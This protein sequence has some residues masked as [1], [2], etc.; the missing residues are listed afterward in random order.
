M[1]NYSY[2]KM[3]RGPVE[4]GSRK[5]ESEREIMKISR[6]DVVVVPPT[7]SIKSAAETMVEYSTRRLPIVHAGT[8]TIQGIVTTRDIIDFL[9]G[10][11]KYNII[12]EKHGGNF[13]A[14]INESVKSIMSPDVVA[15]RDTDSVGTALDRILSEDVGGFPILNKSDKVVGI[16]EEEDFI[17]N[18]A[19]FWS[20][21]KVREA[22]TRDVIIL[23]PGTTIKDTARTMIKN[24]RRR[25][26][27]VS[28]G[29][30]VGVA[31]TFDIISYFGTSQILERMKKTYVDDALSIRISEIMN[32]MPGTIGPDDDLGTA[33]ENMKKT[34]IGFLVVKD[35]CGTIKGVITER[36][37]LSFII[38]EV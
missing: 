26:P 14:A 5:A 32:R 36:D 38:K 12:K 27:V 23:T 30:L 13:L 4:F 35:S 15:I 20:G 37:I 3:D 33:V 25:L 18:L 6:K 8:N 19:G 16:V 2:G 17:Y 28:A 31:T 11:E 34:N 29:E 9:G 24:Y 21:I 1:R 7:M 10:G 22:M